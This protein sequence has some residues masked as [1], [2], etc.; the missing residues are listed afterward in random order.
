MLDLKEVNQVVKM[1]AV[2]ALKR[3]GLRIYNVPATDSDGREAL[4]VTIILL[5]GKR[6]EVSGD[7]A[8]DAIVRIQRDLRR[9][10]EERFPIIEFATDE[11]MAPDVDTQP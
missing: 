1:A 5:G 4:H 11:E 2:A 7:S 10:G 8:L 3:E 9:S 6:K